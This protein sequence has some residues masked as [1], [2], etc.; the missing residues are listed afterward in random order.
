M[1]TLS[2]MTLGVI[3][4]NAIEDQDIDSVWWVVDDLIGKHEDITKVD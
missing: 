2:T 1:T 3:L 4:T